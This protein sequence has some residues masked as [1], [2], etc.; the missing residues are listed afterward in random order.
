MEALV[1]DYGVTVLDP[2]DEIRRLADIYVENGIIPKNYATD[3]LHIAAATVYSM[4]FIV[5]LNFQ[6]IVKHKTILRTDYINTS[7]GYKR[8]FIHAPAEVIDYD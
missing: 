6:H 7:E 8:I 3:A 2:N 1:T 4:D 5:S